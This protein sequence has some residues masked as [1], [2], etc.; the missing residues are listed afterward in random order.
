M[1]GAV[2]S[3]FTA[4]V[5]VLLEQNGSL[6]PI[7]AIEFGASSYSVDRRHLR[8]TFPS[9]NPRSEIHDRQ[10]AVLL[11]PTLVPNAVLLTHYQLE[12]KRKLTPF[13]TSEIHEYTVPPDSAASTLGQKWR[14]LHGCDRRLPCKTSTSGT[15]CRNYFPKRDSI[16]LAISQP[17]PRAT[18][19]P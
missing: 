17:V 1:P 4:N 18:L 3:E 15:K 16:V 7:T 6:L 8:T 19:I 13:C 11:H 10:S 9:P 14:L 2:G 5:S 12:L